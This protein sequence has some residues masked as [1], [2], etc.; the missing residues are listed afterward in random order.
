MFIPNMYI[1]RL[2]VHFEQIEKQ[3]LKQVGRQ[4][5]KVR[6]EYGNLQRLYLRFKENEGSKKWFTIKALIVLQV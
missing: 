3:K 1:S 5:K 2:M 4:L 6:I